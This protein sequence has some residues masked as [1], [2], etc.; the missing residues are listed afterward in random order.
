MS[1][2]SKPPRG[3]NAK[4]PTTERV[5]RA[6]LDAQVFG[7]KAAARKHGVHANTIAMGRATRPLATTVT[8]RCAP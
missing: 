3:H 7:D 5:A 6:L 4:P 8:C 1:A 2:S